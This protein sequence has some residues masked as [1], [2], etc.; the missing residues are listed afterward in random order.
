MLTLKIGCNYIGDYGPAE[1]YRRNNAQL[2]LVSTLLA[3]DSLK[4]PLLPDLL[5]PMEK[6]FM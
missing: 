1:V 4:S 2:Q 3:T 6:I 5:M